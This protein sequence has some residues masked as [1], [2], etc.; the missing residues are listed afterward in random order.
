MT[1]TPA[2]TRAAPQ[3][4]LALAVTHAR[5]LI[6]ES[7]REPITLVSSAVLPVLFLLF[8]VVPFSD[9]ADAV[10]VTPAV[11]QLATFAV[12]STFLFTLGVGVAD[13]RE[14][15]WDP[16]L[17]TLAAPAWP[18]LLGRLLNGY[19]FAIISVVP[20]SITAGLLTTAGAAPWRLMLGL[21]ALLGAATPFLFGGLAIGYT[22]PVKAAVPVTQLVFLPIAFGGGLFLPPAVFPPWLEQVSTMLPTRGA[23]DLVVSAVV[24]TPPETAAVLV[25]LGWAAVTAALAGWAYRRDEGRRYR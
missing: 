16:Y 12:L 24:G 19:V 17:R 14:K 18:R 23:R 2:P 25:L 5:Y 13:D 22:L 9:P 11:A 4:G 6:V 3:A 7:L 20:I 1:A 10:G 21:L 8:F 15:P